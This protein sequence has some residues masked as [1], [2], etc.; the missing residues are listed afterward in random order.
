[1]LMERQT[2]ALRVGAR[3]VER[4][5]GRGRGRGTQAVDKEVESNIGIESET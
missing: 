3:E 5:R 2:V 1:M 4:G